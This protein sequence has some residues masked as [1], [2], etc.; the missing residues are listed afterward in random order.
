MKTPT[1]F[2]SLLLSLQPFAAFA[3][4]R[5]F[6][7]RIFNEEKGTERLV[8]STFDDLQYPTYHPLDPGERIQ[9]VQS[10]RCWG[11]TSKFAPLCLKPEERADNED[12]LEPGA[13]PRTSSSG[14]PAT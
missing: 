1:W 5:A 6:E 2:L 12:A 13:Q 8:R 11:N 7:L 4:Y 3:E 9:I 14:E 10:W